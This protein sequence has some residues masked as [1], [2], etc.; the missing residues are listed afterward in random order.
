MYMCVSI[1]YK[2]WENFRHKFG[3]KIYYITLIFTF[4]HRDNSILKL[5]WLL[6]FSTCEA[7]YRGAGVSISTQ[8]DLFHAVWGSRKAVLCDS[9]AHW[10]NSA[11]RNLSEQTTKN[12]KHT[13]KNKDETNAGKGTFRGAWTDDVNSVSHPSLD[14]LTMKQKGASTAS[15]A[16]LRSGNG[17]Q[18]P[19]TITPAAKW[20]G[21][22]S[23]CRKP[24]C[25]M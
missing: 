3:T 22:D 15:T 5:K 16:K 10:V 4:L 24:N 2:I 13:K 11:M 6:Y 20:E 19:V 7:H 9:R 25:K 21:N 17:S 12:H 1:S 8:F 18:R 14:S 23:Q